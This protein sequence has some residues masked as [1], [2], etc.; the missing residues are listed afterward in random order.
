MLGH[1]SLVARAERRRGLAR[2]SRWLLLDLQLEGAGVRLLGGRGCVDGRP[3]RCVRAVDRAQDLPARV[4]LQ[5]QQGF[6]IGIA[7]V[8]PWLTC[9]FLG[10][11]PLTA[12]QQGGA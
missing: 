5:L 6:S 11:L 4:S 9:P 7:A 3:F 2:A 10:L 1:C 12:T 8:R